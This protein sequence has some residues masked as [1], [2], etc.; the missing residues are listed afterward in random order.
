MPQPNGLT[1]SSANDR[2]CVSRL[3]RA[4]TQASGGFR[5]LPVGF[6]QVATGLP[7][8]ARRIDGP[9]RRGVTG[10]LLLAGGR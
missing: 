4:W 8:A 5:H 10:P 6:S 7:R 9:V 1:S 3:E 2:G